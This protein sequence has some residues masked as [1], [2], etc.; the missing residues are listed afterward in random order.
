MGITQEKRRE[1]NQR[2]Y[3]K[4]RNDP[5]QWARTLAQG[6]KRYHAKGGHKRIPSLCIVCGKRWQGSHHPRRF[7]SQKCVS[8]GVH[9]GRWN[10]GRYVTPAGYVMVWCPTHPAAY[11]KQYVPEHR[12]IM[13]KSLQRLLTTAEQVHH[14]N[15]IKTDNRLCNLQLIS[16]SGHAHIHLQESRQRK[17][18]I[19]ENKGIQCRTCR[20]WKT[21]EHFHRKRTSWSGR[22]T[23]CKPCQAQYINPYKKQWRLKQLS[24]K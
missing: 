16:A 3:W 1:Y 15:G 12:L 7:C 17:Q 21:V 22:S 19:L 10:G 6:R 14:R 8:Q 24:S 18:R 9:N 4:R 11:R 20:Q 23:R 5:H 2:A 13:E